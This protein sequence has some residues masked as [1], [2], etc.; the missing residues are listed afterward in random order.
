[1]SD[2]AA[3]K[4]PY[5]GIIPKAERTSYYLGAFGQGMMYSIMSS[6]I[7]DFYMNV[8]GLGAM[9]VFWLTL[10]SRVWDAANDPIMGVIMDRVNPKHGKMR[11]YLFYF[12]LPIA[13]LT[14]LMFVKPNLPPTFMMVYAAVTYVL[15]DFLYTIGDVPFWSAP[16]AMTPNHEER[17]F[18]ASFARTTNGIGS[19][20]PMGLFMAIGPVLARMNTAPDKIEPQKYLVT[21]LICAGVGFILFFQT[22][23]KMKE[24]VPLPKEEKPDKGILKQVLKCKPLMLISA[25]SILAGGRYMLSAA[26]IHVARYAFFNGDLNAL[27]T[28]SDYDQTKAVQDSITFVSLI[29]QVSLAAGMFLAMMITPLLYKKYNY[30]QLVIGSCLIGGAAGLAMYFVGYSSVYALIPFLFI[31]SIPVGVINVVAIAMLGDCLDFM[32]WETGIRENG[33]GM[34]CQSFTQKVA[35]AIATAA[36]VLTY[37]FVGLNVNDFADSTGANLLGVALNMP[38]KLSSV[39]GGMFSLVSLVPAISLLVCVIP[40]LFYDLTGEKK[41]RVMRELAERRAKEAEQPALVEA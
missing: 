30:K 35:N 41:E 3:E 9:F 23:F 18:L 36:I 29:F 14:I 19:A 37:G 31:C 24:R 40:M 8:M 15:W 7:S 22:P 32:E 34:A 27:Y 39:R 5:A 16:N 33:L 25:M 2:K 21:V 20:V 28:M 6:F 1:M 12:P 26:A 11:T 38:E 13:L 10:L 4:K 17:G